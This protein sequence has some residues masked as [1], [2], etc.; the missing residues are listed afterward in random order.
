[1]QP[2]LHRQLV[3]VTEYGVRCVL[4]VTVDEKQTAYDQG[5]IFLWIGIDKET[6]LVPTFALG[7]RSGDMARRFCTDLAG[8]LNRPNPHASDDHAFGQG[9]YMQ[10]VQISTDGFAAY[11]EAIDLAFGPYAEHG[12]IIKEYRNS[13]MQYD[14]S[15]MV[16][17]QRRVVSG[18]IDEWSIVRATLSG[19]T[20]LPACSSNGSTG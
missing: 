5:D 15:E 6:R 20:R 4:R 13:H 7:K 11:G 1:L 18:K 17:T 8:R 19:S 3:D 2:W 10:R 14:P 12:V 9:S 16:G